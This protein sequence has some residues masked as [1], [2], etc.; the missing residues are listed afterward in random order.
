VAN[1][2]LTYNEI[3]DYGRLIM[4]GIDCPNSDCEEVTS[5]DG[6]YWYRGMVEEE[7]TQAQVNNILD[8][9]S[10]ESVILGHTK[11]SNIRSL[12]EGRVIAIDMFHVNNFSN[13]F[14]KALQFELGCFFSFRTSASGET[15]TP[16]D[17]NCEQILGT[18]LELNGENQLKLY[19]NPS[20]NF[21]NI[22]MPSN[23]IGEYNYTIINMGGSQVSQGLINQEL[24]TI[25]IGAYATGK[26]ILI[27]QNS[28]RI[29]KGSFILK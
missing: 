16:L 3:N 29:I 18:A 17:P 21:L 1:L 20:S 15:Y 10:V 27:I 6:I 5:G 9:F 12:Y 2:N 22:K 11:A 14:M 4:N 28:D 19:P 7:L 26:Y 25:G 23:M 24:S 13:G 8:G